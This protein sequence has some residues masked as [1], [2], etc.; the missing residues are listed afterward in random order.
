MR[1]EIDSLRAHVQERDARLVAQTAE[2]RTKSE[3]KEQQIVSLRDQVRWRDAQLA[4]WRA[5]RS[6][7][8][9]ASEADMGAL[10]QQWTL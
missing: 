3:E 5:T 8:Q 2:S 10:S 1:L 7:R 4:C 6:T 9:L